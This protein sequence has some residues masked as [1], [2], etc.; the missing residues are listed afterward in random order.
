M[1]DVTLPSMGSDQD[2]TAFAA[3]ASAVVRQATTFVGL[4]DA[5]FRP[6][7]LNAVGRDMVGLSADS[8]P[9][10]VFLFDGC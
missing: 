3:I 2:G 6:F 9:L 8:S 7:F 1:S 4:C 5:E 10:I